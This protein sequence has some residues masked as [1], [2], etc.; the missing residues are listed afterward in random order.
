LTRRLCVRAALLALLTVCGLQWL[1]QGARAH[2]YPNSVITISINERRLTLTISVPAPELLHVL[3]GDAYQNAEAYLAKDPQALSFYLDAHLAVLDKGGAMLP[4]VTSA[5]SVAK[6]SDPDVGEYEEFRFEIEAPVPAGS[7]A[8]ALSLRYDA[9]IHQIP[10][11]FA[12]VRIS[13][14]FRGGLVGQASP[15]ELG[16]IRYDFASKTVPPLAINAGQ[17]SLWTGFKAIVSL[18]LH[19]VAGGLDH[20]LFLA[21][22]LAVAPLRVV[23]GGWSLFQ[24]YGYSIRRFLAIS[25]A[26]TLGHSVSLAIGAYQLVSVNT[27]LVEVLIA[28]SILLAALHAFRP[29]FSGREWLVS[30]GFG[31]VHGLAFSA[32]LSGLHLPPLDN[33]AAIFGFNIGVEAAQLLVMAAA[34]PLMLLSRYELFHTLRRAAMILVAMLAALWIGERAFGVPLPEFLIV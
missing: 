2:P 33:A 20:I 29:V 8:R 21:T 16:V 5:V 13:Q 28:F 15:V 11:H 30:G 24:G 22:L 12:L 26:F 6:T 31:L 3:T 10:N 25:I 27:T 32:S 18:G 14:D 19:H 17:G 34:L 9:V 7:D 4:H 1:A 23:N